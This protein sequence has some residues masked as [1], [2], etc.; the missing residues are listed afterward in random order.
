MVRWMVGVASAVVIMA[1]CIAAPTQ[2]AGDPNCPAGLRPCQRTADGWL[3]ENRVLRDAY[4]SIQEGPVVTLRNVTL[5]GN[6]S[7]SFGCDCLLR[8]EGF[9]VVGSGLSNQSLAIWN[10]DETTPFRIDGM[11][12]SGMDYGI[13]LWDARQPAVFS[14]VTIDCMRV[15]FSAV[16][17]PSDLTFKDSV[18]Q[19]CAQ[20][21]VHDLAIGLDE[22]SSL[23]LDRVKILNATVGVELFAGFR[24]EV[25][26]SQFE[27]NGMYG[28]YGDEGLWLNVTGSSFTNNGALCPGGCGAAIA[29]EVQGGA[30]GAVFSGN[31]WALDISCKNWPG[32]D[33]PGPDAFDAASNWWGDSLGPR[34]DLG[35]GPT[36]PGQ[37]DLVTG[38]VDT[39]PWLTSPP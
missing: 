3:V 7:I 39:A 6:V 17:G 27:G 18:I 12:V 5:A 31:R 10:H 25:L 24:M 30:H 34:H 28:I 1:G 16:V 32:G 21:A 8:G 29:G 13:Q 2:P 38:C 15:G 19:G 22:R 20:I 11:H 26:E 9:E 4:L 23:R 33:V 35:A 37:G 14:N 36:G